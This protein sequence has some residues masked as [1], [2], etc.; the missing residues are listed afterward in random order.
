MISQKILDYNDDTLTYH[1]CVNE[2]EAKKE[3]LPQGLYFFWTLG[4]QKITN[5]FEAVQ[6]YLKA[7]ESE[8]SEIRKLVTPQNLAKH[9]NK[10]H[11]T[12]METLKKSMRQT[13]QMYEKLYAQSGMNHQAIKA[14]QDT[15]NKQMDYYDKI[16]FPGINGMFKPT[17]KQ[18]EAMAGSIENLN[19]VM[20]D[21]VQKKVFG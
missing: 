4:S 9:Y 12:Q 16:G 6:I 20:P 15:M 2:K 19:K 7:T 17:K 8:Q 5:P 14:M 11:L 13:K 3:K 1:Q 10:V 18:A 21:E